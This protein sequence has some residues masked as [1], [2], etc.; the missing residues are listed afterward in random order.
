MRSIWD[1]PGTVDSSVVTG[2][3]HSSVYYREKLTSGFLLLIKIMQCF[4]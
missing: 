1:D 4:F 2:L 3:D